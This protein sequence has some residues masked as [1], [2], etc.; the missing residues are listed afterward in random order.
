M[1]LL[2]VED[3]YLLN[4]T[5]QNYFESCSFEVEAC[6]DAA[7]ALQ[8]A[9]DAIDCCLVDVDLPDIDGIEILKSLR[10]QF[11]M[12]PV[13]M[14]SATTDIG[15]INRAYENGC[16]DYLKKPFDIREL[17]WKIK[18]IVQK[19]KEEVFLENEYRFN[20]KNHQL[21]YRDDE[22]RLTHKERLLMD[23]LCANQQR[24]VPHEM[25]ENVLWEE[26]EMPHLRQLLGRLRKK[27][28]KPLIET[29]IG[30]GYIVK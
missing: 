7:S 16:S 18:L 3:D 19:G 12:L 29:R 17:E 30:E 6:A 8:K 22:I 24:V 11:P 13:I 25:I 1:K 20:Q 2:L 15:T 28:P 14:I 23:L 10:K 5:I 21:F 4:K 9:A 26:D 27:L